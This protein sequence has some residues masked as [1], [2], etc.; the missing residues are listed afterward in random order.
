MVVMLLCV[1][2][3]YV[4]FRL[5]V[6][7]DPMLTIWRRSFWAS[8]LRAHVMI[9]NGFRRQDFCKAGLVNALETPHP[10]FIRLLQPFKRQC[11]FVVAL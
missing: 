5:E 1:F 11:G 2:D 3:I 4:S 7:I 6:T 8:W 10:Y 9:I